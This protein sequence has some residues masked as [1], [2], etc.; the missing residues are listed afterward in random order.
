VEDE[1]IKALENVTNLYIFPAKKKIVIMDFDFKI[2]KEQFRKF[3]DWLTSNG[4]VEM[5]FENNAE[6][7]SLFMELGYEVENADKE[8]LKK[9]SVKYQH[10]DG[11]KSVLMNYIVD[12]AVTIEDIIYF[13]K[14]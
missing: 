7:L 4:F 14:S 8:D 9:R 1:I 6:I 10:T 13:E 3:H 2:T 11:K 5:K 12:D